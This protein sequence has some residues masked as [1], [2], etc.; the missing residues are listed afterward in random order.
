MKP[1]LQKKIREIGEYEGSV[2]VFEDILD[3]DKKPFTRGTH[4]NV[5]VCYSSD[6]YFD[7]PTK[8]IADKSNTIILFGRTLK[9]LENYYKEN[10]G[11]DMTYEEFKKPCR[12]VWEDKDYHY[13]FTDRTQQNSEGK[14][15]IYNE[16]K[17]HFH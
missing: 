6:S 15:C 4:Q 11:F 7:L 13:L 14:C 10:A 12:D 3:H 16:N 8:T 9:D 17:K 2:V 1:I 5:V